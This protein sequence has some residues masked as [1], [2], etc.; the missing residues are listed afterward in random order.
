LHSLIYL[1]LHSNLYDY[2]YC[3]NALYSLSWTPHWSLP[4][5]CLLQSV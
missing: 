4:P 3:Q 1:L 2:D 5:T